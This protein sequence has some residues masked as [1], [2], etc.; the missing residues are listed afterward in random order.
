MSVINDVVVP[1]IVSGVTGI[2]AWLA[3]RKKYA[4]ELEQLKTDVAKA[5]Q[6]VEKAKNEVSAS[7]LENVEKS[8]A[9]YRGMVEDLG[10]RVSILSQNINTLMKD[11]Q[12]LIAEN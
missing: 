3:A 6:E 9:I 10:Q 11:N 2:A 8:I 5:E 7:E 12:D 1:A 4:V